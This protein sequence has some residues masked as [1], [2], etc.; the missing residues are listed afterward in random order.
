V[1]NADGRI[2]KSLGVGKAGRIDVSMPLAKAPT[3]FAR[4]GN[5][6][7]L[8]FAALLIMLAFLPLVSTRA[9]R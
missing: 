3:P 7:P 2:V 5:I 8:G 1:I 9:S 4:L 6:L